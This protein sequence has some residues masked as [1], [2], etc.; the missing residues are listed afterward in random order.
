MKVTKGMFRINSS[1]ELG[2]TEHEGSYAIAFPFYVHRTEEQK[3]WRLSH[4]ATGRN[5]IANIRTIQKAREL[6]QELSKYSVFL[7]PC[8]DT[9]TMAIE[10]MKSNNPQEYTELL[11][12]VKGDY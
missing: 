6:A 2:W 11:A 7:M 3:S 5:I 1:E 12:I 10:R 8:I 9:W 4:M